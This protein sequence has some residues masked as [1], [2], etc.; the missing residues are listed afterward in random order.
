MPTCAPEINSHVREF[1]RS[2][3][4]NH[5]RRLDI[6]LLCLTYLQYRSE[7]NGNFYEYKLLLM[8]DTQCARPNNYRFKMSMLS[9]LESYYCLNKG[10][11]YHRL[12]LFACQTRRL[13]APS[14]VY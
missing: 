4:I 8:D 6:R 5:S 12:S 3:L 13:T 9:Q 10:R 1:K 14:I 11:L 2:T 7:L